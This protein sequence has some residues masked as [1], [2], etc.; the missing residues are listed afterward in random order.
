MDVFDLSV[1]IP[2]YKEYQ[3]I[4]Q[5]LDSLNKS[6]FSDFNILV[7]DHG[8]SDEITQRI[9]KDFPEVKCLRGSS[10]LWW[11]GATNIGV[12]YAVGMGSKRIIPLNH[13]CYV[14]TDTISK[15]VCAS[16]QVLN[17]IVAPVQYSLSNKTDLVCA[18][19]FFLLGFPTVIIPAKWCRKRNKKS[20]LSTGLIIGGR[21]AIIHAEIFKKIGYFDETDLPHYGADHDFY[22][23][24]KKSGIK[25][26]TCLDSRLDVDDYPP[27]Q[28]SIQK[29]TRASS[30]IDTLT[31][32]SSHRNIKDTYT[33]FSRYY[34]LPGLAFLGMGLYLLRYSL[35]YLLKSGRY[36]FTEN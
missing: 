17:S 4:R 34:P 5:C 3:K 12:K 21:G 15:I 18:A 24:C 20:L 11:T 6:D 32:R 2:A 1:V 9:N 26:L 14:H 33:L 22:L 35:V 28:G 16:D 25:L 23:R 8:E 36:F 29:N 30:F 19:S 7:V 31:K 13:D 27:K 10:D